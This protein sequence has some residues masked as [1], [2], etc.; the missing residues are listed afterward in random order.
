MYKSDKMNVIG[1]FD[2][3]RVATLEPRPNSVLIMMTSVN[4]EFPVL[5]NHW[6]SILKLKFDDVEGKECDIGNSSN[7][8]QDSHAEQILDFVIENIDKDIFVSCDA[9]LSRS[10]GV[11]VALELIFN[12]RDVSDEYPHHNKF[13][14]NKIRDVWFKKIWMNRTSYS[15]QDSC[16]SSNNIGYMKKFG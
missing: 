12:S 2:R 13:V 11:V 16:I 1:A 7:V 8:M 6:S 3:G 5:N 10:P 15:N 4:S 9:G 14:K